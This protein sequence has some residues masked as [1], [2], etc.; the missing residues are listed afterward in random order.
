MKATTGKPVFAARARRNSSICGVL[1]VHECETVLSPPAWTRFSLD[2]AYQK[3]SR[4]RCHQLQVQVKSKD[5]RL[6]GPV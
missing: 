4:T 5:G 6:R 1:Q 2:L 3:L